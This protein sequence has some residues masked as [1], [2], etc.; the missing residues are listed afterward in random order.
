M[1]LVRKTYNLRDKR[2]NQ[3]DKFKT[4]VALEA[5]KEQLTISEIES[6]YEIHPNLVSQWKKRLLDRSESAFNDK[7]KQKNDNDEKLV[8]NLY[9]QIGQLKVEV[10]W[11]KK[12]TGF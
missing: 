8:D 7:R 4:K 6:K 11:L 9:R 3:S 12:K 5:L 10:D 1:C 2:K